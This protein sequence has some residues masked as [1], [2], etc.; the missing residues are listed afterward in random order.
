MRLR[1]YL[2]VS[3]S[4]GIEVRKRLPESVGGNVVIPMFVIIPDAAF[5]R[6]TSMVTVNV[7]ESSI[8]QPTAEV[9][10]DER[11]EPSS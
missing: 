9:V 4:G 8:I 1:F 3:E 11:K 6:T 5:V 7:P 2:I 10:L